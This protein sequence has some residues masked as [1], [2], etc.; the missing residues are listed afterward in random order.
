MQA[1]KDVTVQSTPRGDDGQVSIIEKVPVITLH[2]CVGLEI[3]VSGYTHHTANQSRQALW[4]WGL[5]T[6]KQ[7]DWILSE[8]D[9]PEL[10]LVKERQGYLTYTAGWGQSHKMDSDGLRLVDV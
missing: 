5:S 7:M 1:T 4:R 9:T 8:V 3:H 2:K 10:T 6:V